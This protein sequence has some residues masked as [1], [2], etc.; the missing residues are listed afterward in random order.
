MA[1]LG[2]GG[3]LASV[4]ALALFR[5][6]NPSPPD[7]LG[8][9]RMFH[10]W[11]RVNPEPVEIGYRADALCVNPSPE[12]RHKAESNPHRFKTITV[13]VNAQGKRT[14]MR[15]GTFPVGSVIVKEKRQ[16]KTGPVELSTVMIKRPRGF[17]PSCGDWEFAVLDRSG[18]KVQ[19]R[20][21]L[22]TC[23]ACHVEQV[24]TDYVFRGYVP[25]NPDPR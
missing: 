25:K 9:V 13:W 6:Q 19:A 5:G 17:N 18:E 2:M 7:R 15:G 10:T 11:T 4:S 20:G 21:K 12:L 1:L 8:E 22:S 3:V 23:Q 16:E 24:K 14:M